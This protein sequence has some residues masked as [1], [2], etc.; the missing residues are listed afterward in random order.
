MQVTHPY[1]LDDDAG[2]APSHVDVGGRRVPVEGDGTFIVDA[3]DAESWLQSFAAAYDATADDLV[4]DQDAD[5]ADQDAGPDTCDTELTDGGICGRELP[6]PYH[7][8]DE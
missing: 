3:D 5:Q 7:S 6:C 4:V 1:A 8:E 2:P